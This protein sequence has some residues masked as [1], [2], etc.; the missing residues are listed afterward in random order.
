RGEG[1]IEFT[2]IS[3]KRMQSVQVK[4]MQ[5]QITLDVREWK[6]GLYVATLK[7]GVKITQSVK[8]TIAD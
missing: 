8:F 2:D 5:D 1:V 3:G 7:T 4:H 6:S